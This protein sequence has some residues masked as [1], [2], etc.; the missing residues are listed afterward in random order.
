MDALL[1]VRAEEEK[2]ELARKLYHSAKLGEEVVLGSF[3]HAGCLCDIGIVLTT[4]RQL[5]FD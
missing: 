3:C 1:L 2:V 4:M 5:P